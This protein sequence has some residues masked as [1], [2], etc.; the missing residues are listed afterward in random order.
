MVVNLVVCGGRSILWDVSLTTTWDRRGVTSLLRTSCCVA[1]S[2]DNSLGPQ[3]SPPGV[4]QGQAAVR[5]TTRGRSSLGVILSGT[6]GSHS[7]HLETKSLIFVV[8][9]CRQSRAHA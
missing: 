9:E 2:P 8:W 1:H 7:L 6:V 4:E 5:D 3:A